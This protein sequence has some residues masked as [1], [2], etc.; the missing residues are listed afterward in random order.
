MQFRNI[1]PKPLFTLNSKWIIFI[2]AYSKQFLHEMGIKY[3]TNTDC[4]HDGFQRFWPKAQTTDIWEDG[5]HKLMPK[6]D[7]CLNI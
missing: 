2:H 7:E 4:S 1:R 5:V 6:Y 3:F